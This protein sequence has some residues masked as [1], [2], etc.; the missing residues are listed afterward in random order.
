MH[1]IKPTIHK[2]NG[3][4]KAG[5]GFSPD[6]LAKAGV[7]KLQAR[8]MGLPVDWRRRTSHDENVENI[9]A[10]ADK[11]KADAE[12]KAAVKPAVTEKKAKSK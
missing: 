12:A 7:N 11:A 4:V 1:H 6:E 3:K 5:R 8:Q 2:P 10:H 9:K